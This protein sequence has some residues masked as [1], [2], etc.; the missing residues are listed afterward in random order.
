MPD[1]L[2][3]QRLLQEYLSGEL[4][5]LNAHLPSEPKTLPALLAEEYPSVIASDGS[6]H[7][8]KRKELE[9]LAGLLDADE[10]AALRLPLI[11]A[12]HPGENEVA[13][14]C[15]GEAE[16]K[17]IARVLDMPLTAREGRVLIYRPQLARI[18]K[19]LKTTTQYLFA[20]P[21]RQANPSLK[22]NGFQGE[23]LP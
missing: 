8:F 23:R 5:V 18:R 14:I 15:R 13:I 21:A 19:V 7:L 2:P 3:Y 20:P 4:R 22:A 1:E 11:I 17:V 6:T 9:Y 12:V 16:K 10:Q